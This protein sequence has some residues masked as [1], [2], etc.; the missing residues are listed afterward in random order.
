MLQRMGS[1]AGLLFLD[2]PLFSRNGRD[3]Y[4]AK[5]HI[6][7]KFPALAPEYILPGDKSSMWNFLPRKA[8][9]IMCDFDA[10]HVSVLAR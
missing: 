5:E 1:D 4:S 8:D 7:L 2:V 9:L 6:P 3:F 10:W